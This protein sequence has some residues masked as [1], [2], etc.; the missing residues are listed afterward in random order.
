DFPAVTVGPTFEKDGKISLRLFIDRSS[1]E[2]F[3]NGGRT[4][5]TNL[6]FPTQPYTGLRIA[7]DG[8]S[9]RLNDLKIYS[10]SAE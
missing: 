9:A 8:N 6:V 7:S 1:I 4:A 2:L 3:S 10:L 5:M